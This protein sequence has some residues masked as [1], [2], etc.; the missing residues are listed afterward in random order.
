MQDQYALLRLALHRNEA[1]HRSP[2]RKSPRHL[3]R[4]SSL[5]AALDARAFQP[6][7]PGDRVRSS[8][9]PFLAA[10]QEATGGM[11]ICGS[12][13]NLLQELSSSGTTAGFPDPDLFDHGAHSGHRLPTPSSPAPVLCG[14]AY[15]SCSHTSRRISIILFSIATTH[16]GWLAMN[17]QNCR[18]DSFLR[19]TR[20]P[21]LRLRAA[22][23]RSLQGRLR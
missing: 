21:S 4:R 23:R 5:V 8:L 11:M 10:F 6:D 19:N 1:H 17:L 2:P 15:P 18:R 3:R 13:P 16:A 12:G 9:R 20:E 14:D 7:V 22:E